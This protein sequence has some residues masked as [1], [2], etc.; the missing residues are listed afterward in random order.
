[1]R[2]PPFSSKRF[3]HIFPWLVSS[4]DAIAPLVSFPLEGIRTAT[5]AFE[6]HAEA[7]ARGRLEASE[8][9]GLITSQRMMEANTAVVRSQNSTIGSLLDALA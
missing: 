3:D 2:K 6:R 7:I 5:S 9:A 1:M 8:F 4:I